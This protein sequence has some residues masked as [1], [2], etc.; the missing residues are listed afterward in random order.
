VYKTP[1]FGFVDVQ[2]VGNVPKEMKKVIE[3]SLRKSKA[4]SVHRY[5]KDIN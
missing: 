4:T 5:S 3:K 2:Y 1:E